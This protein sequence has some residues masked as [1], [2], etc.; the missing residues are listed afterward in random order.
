MYAGFTFDDIPGDGIHIPNGYQGL[1]WD[2]WFMLD[3]DEYEIR[4][5]YYAGNVQR[6]SH[7]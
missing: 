7:L 2:N 4:N 5:G 3:G 6:P 1:L